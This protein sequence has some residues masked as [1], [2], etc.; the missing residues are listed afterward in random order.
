MTKRKTYSVVA[1]V[2]LLGTFFYV[3]V[4]P[5]VVG[6]SNMRAF[7]VSMEK[8][9]QVSRVRDM[10]E[11]KRYRI[12]SPDKAGLALVHDPGSFGRYIC[13]VRFREDRLESARYRQND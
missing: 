12:T 6:E 2:L 4:W 7:C 5:F 8:G 11:Q 1:A 13:E 9:A 10:V 3:A